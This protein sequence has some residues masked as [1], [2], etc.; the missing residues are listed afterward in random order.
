MEDQLR[1]QCRRGVRRVLAQ[2]GWGLVQ[3]EAAFVEEVLAEVRV[4][5]PNSSRPLEKLIED[6]TVNR[7]GH[8]WHAACGAEGTLRQRRA[9]TELH[10]YLYRIALYCAKHDRH[11]AEESAQE[12]L[13]AVWQHLGQVR[14]PGSFARWAGAI[15]SRKVKAALRQRVRRVEKEKGQEVMW[16]I[17]EISETDLGVRGGV[18]R[19]GVEA[20]EINDQPGV[21]VAQ[22]SKMT[23][24]MRARI[25]AAIRRCLRSKQQQAVIIGLFLDEK[26]FKEVADALGKKLENVYVLKSRALARLRKCEEFLR[27]LEDLL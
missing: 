13:I 1:E 24:E 2:R 10:R 17:R 8:L 4:R 19:G 6:A 9:F 5:L 12:A 20:W 18:E 25:E 3:D 11:I 23:G 26:S 22:G 14:D 7:Y 15:V 16:E 27:V 21:S